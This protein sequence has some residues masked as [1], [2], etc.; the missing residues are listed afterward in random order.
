MR[1]IGLDLGKCISLCE[2]SG[3]D[4]VRRATVRSLE[5]L[6]QYLGA[7]TPPAQVAF[8][9]SREAWHVADWLR[10]RGKTPRL[11]DT[12]R[13]KQMGIGQHRRKNDQLDAEVLARAL[14]ERRLPEA[15][16]LSEPR[17][18]LRRALNAR[19]LLVETRTKCVVHIRGVAAS[20]GQRL[21][22][23]HAED[24]CKNLEQRWQLSEALG[25]EIAPQASVLGATVTALE[26]ADA[27]LEEVAKLEPVIE[28][29]QTVPG[30]GLIVAASFVSVID[31]PKRFGSA[32]QVESYLGLVPAEASTGGK[33]R[34]GSITKHG[35]SYARAELVQAAQSILR[36]RT[37]FQ[38]PLR[39]W[40]EK[41]R[42]RRGTRVA[43]VALARRL[44]GI[45]WAMWRD[46]TVFERD[47]SST[48]QPRVKGA[49]VKPF[50][51]ERDGI[52]VPAVDH[53]LLNAPS[54]FRREA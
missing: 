38:G 37:S 10:A 33:R 52:A 7:D 17:Q 18:K 13:A 25:A 27:H 32:H 15:H 46:G 36:P 28:Q 51:E 44:A 16:E 6:E 41:V 21:P 53:E 50:P 47:R 42:R 48:Q 1:T 31:D 30:V 49:L 39:S 5:A 19:A 26:K 45:L 22:G 9:A 24:F 43:A 2:V 11:A 3:D 8:E 54:T 14:A 35:N 40:A 29:L 4:V 34:L 12:T 23:C 20:R